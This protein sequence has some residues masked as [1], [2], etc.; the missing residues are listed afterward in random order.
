MLHGTGLNNSCEIANSDQEFITKI[1]D[2]MAVEYTLEKSKVREVDLQPY[3]D[4]VKAQKFIDLVL[5]L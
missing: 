4:D 1:N 5:K 2:L 3:H